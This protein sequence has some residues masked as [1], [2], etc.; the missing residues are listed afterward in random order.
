M[1]ALEPAE[2]SSVLIERLWPIPLASR[3][4]GLTPRTVLATLKRLA[5]PRRTERIPG[6]AAYRR[7]VSTSDLVALAN[8]RLA[9]ATANGHRN[10]A[11]HTG[12][13]R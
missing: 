13:P 6:R 3:M 9:A 8:H 1:N 10:L 12:R 11:A 4:L 7:V 5:L 2:K